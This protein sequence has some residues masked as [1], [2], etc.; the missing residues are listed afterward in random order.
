MLTFLTGVLLVLVP[1][2]FLWRYARQDAVS[3]EEEKQR[4]EQERDVVLRFMHN[5]V[6][7]MGDGVNRQ[8]LFERII[9]AAVLGTGAVSGAVYE[10]TVGGRLEKA[11]MEG[12]FPPQ[13]GLDGSAA[14]SSRTALL[15]EV[16]RR[17]VIA[18]GEG[19]IGQVG[20]L[21][22][23]VLI[24]DAAADPRLVRHEDPAL[25]ISSMIVV[26]M[27]FRDQVQG[28]LAVA[29]PSDG[30][31]FSS[32][33]FSLM[34]TLAEQAGLALFNARQLDRLREQQKLEMDLAL[35]RNV[36]GML[37]PE[38]V[39]HILGLDANTFYRPAQQ[40][41][42]DMYNFVELGPRKLGVMVA[43]VS[44]KG[45][46]ASLLM[47]ICQTHFG[48][49]AGRND[50]P[51]AVL[52]EMNRLV[53][54][55]LREDMFVTMLYVVVDTAAGTARMARAGHEPLLLVRPGREGGPAE[56]TRLLPEGMALGMVESELFDAVLEERCALLKPGDS[57]LFYTDGLTEATNRRGKE[58]SLDRLI[59]LAA[60]SATLGAAEIQSRILE[61]VRDF[62][63]L[64]AAPDD[65]T[66]VVLKRVEG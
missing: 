21:G 50:S 28:V 66:L 40:V 42:G 35:A 37:L 30:T 36:Q 33:D 9:H 22:E 54:G 34:K 20:Q 18:M 53:R 61:S 58:F 41:G 38:Q 52:R 31:T 11:A 3:L 25:Q 29:N 55:Q 43:D 59:D 48:H 24:E 44:G 2:W 7:C 49:L 23:S 56:V 45:V 57:L 19:L 12:L 1:G 10:V 47:S 13:Q 64:E 14:N 8:L 51:A 6:E 17:E 16:S 5:L 15:E 65:L 46:A 27:K 4:L 60:D 26:P 62:S 32:T 63:G 39:P